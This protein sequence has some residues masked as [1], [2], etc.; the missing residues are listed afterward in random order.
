MSVASA[1]CTLWG[2]V[3]ALVGELVG[4]REAPGTEAEV[5][6]TEAHH[7]SLNKIRNHMISRFNTVMFENGNECRKLMGYTI[8]AYPSKLSP[9]VITLNNIGLLAL[10]KIWDAT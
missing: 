6:M 8:V 3:N 10:W 5:A 2:E 7:A 1:H 4:H 9:S